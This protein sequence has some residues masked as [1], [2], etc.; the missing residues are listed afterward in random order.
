[1]DIEPTYLVIIFLLS[2]V[3]YQQGAG[4]HSAANMFKHS[5]E[6]LIEEYPVSSVQYPIILEI[7]SWMRDT[8]EHEISHY[9]VRLST[10]GNNCFSMPL[11]GFSCHLFMPLHFY[12]YI[13]KKD[14]K[15][16]TKLLSGVLTLSF[17]VQSLVLLPLNYR[18]EALLHYV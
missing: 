13:Y 7:K 3:L 6:T 17:T 5:I 12:I 1:M 16:G 2:A 10:C 14:Y 15:Q 8:W 4:F 18:R 9:M 11:A